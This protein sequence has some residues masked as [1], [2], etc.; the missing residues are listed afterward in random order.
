[1]FFLTLSLLIHSQAFA[2]ENEVS[3]TSDRMNY[4]V[5]AGR[6]VAEG[7]VV[8]KGHGLTLTAERGEGFIDKQTFNIAGNIIVSGVWRG[9]E[10][11]LSAKSAAASMGAPATYTLESEI[12]GNIGNIYIDCSYLQM[13][14]DDVVVRNVRKLQDTK[15]GMTFIADNAKAKILNQ[16]FEQVEASGNLTFIGIPGKTGEVVVVRGKMAVY[17]VQRGT[18]VVSGGV[19]AVQNKRT[20]RAESIIYFPKTN[21]LEAVGKPRITINIEDEKLKK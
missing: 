4:D 13:V 3:L 21:R 1:M 14:G 17:S 9:D 20:I 18:V 15:S 16:Q 8:I 10:V 5:E 19:T 12:S 2:A 11:N 7:N 6:F